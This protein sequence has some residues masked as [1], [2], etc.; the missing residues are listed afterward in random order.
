M[1]RGVGKV[2]EYREDLIASGK[3][4]EMP[5]SAGDPLSGYAGQRPAGIRWHRR[6]SG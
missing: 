5:P 2:K 4:R 6:V 1:Q 3:Y